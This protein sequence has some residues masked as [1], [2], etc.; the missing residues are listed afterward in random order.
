VGSRRISLLDEEKV[1][2][3]LE[4]RKDKRERRIARAGCLLLK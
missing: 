2:H 1:N 3:V 4:K